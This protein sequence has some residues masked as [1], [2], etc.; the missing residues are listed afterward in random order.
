MATSKQ[1]LGT[2]GEQLVTKSCDCPKCKRSKTLKLLPPNFKCADLICDFCGFL[3]QVKTMT[4]PAVSPLP[5]RILGAAWTPQKERMDSGIYFP[6]FL[7]LKA[8][9]DYAIHYLPTDFQSPALFS[10]RK[11]LSNTA[12]RAG[13][14]GF[15]YVLEALPEGAF[16]RLV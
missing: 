16:V 15:M 4:V 6:L 13:W 3:C 12:R 9:N 1:L 7:V 14:Q 8:A 2:W 10:A 5:K 11:P